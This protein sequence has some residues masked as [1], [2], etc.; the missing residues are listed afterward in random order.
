MIQL[1]PDFKEFLQLLLGREVRFLL[2]GGYAVSAFGHVRNTLDIDLWID[3]R[4]ENRVRV[5]AVIR[6]FAF[7]SAQDNL[8]DDPKT[9]LRMGEP[10][11][12]IEILQ[13]IA[14]VTFDECWERREVFEIESLLIPTISLSDLKQ[15]KRAAG[16][17]KDL[18]DLDALS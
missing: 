11:L 7:P 18:A 13:S 17:P 15:N 5:L 1:P 9:I 14:G 2:I 3:S 6:E 16:R 12:R 4:P 10:P 8:L